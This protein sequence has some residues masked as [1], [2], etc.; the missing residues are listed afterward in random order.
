MEKER[1]GE[2]ESQEVAMSDLFSDL[3]KTSLDLT[4]THLTNALIAWICLCSNQLPTF[5]NKA[6]ALSIS[7]KFRPSL[8]KK[9]CHDFT[10]APQVLE[11][12]CLHP[13]LTSIWISGS[14]GTDCIAAEMVIF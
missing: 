5:R 8:H 14:V 9:Q 1:E 3:Q 2:R 10:F 11:P 7:R 12:R 4:N 13:L 6:Q